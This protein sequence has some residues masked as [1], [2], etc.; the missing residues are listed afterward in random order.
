MWRPVGA[1]YFHRK[2]SKKV[3]LTPKIIESFVVTKRACLIQVPQHSESKFHQDN[4]KS[5]GSTIHHRAAISATSLPRQ[6]MS[7]IEGDNSSSPSQPS[8]YNP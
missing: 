6:E 8:L 3:A 1:I 4:D 7:A 5:K 2:G